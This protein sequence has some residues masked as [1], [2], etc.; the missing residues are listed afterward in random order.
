MR[1]C[2]CGL[3]T[4]GVGEEK[5]IYIYVIQRI[6]TENG[7]AVEQGS[8]KNTQNFLEAASQQ[9]VLLGKS[10]ALDPIV[11]IVNASHLISFTKHEARR[12]KMSK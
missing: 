9:K 1:I 11:V 5:N 6:K 2:A 7:T 12:K 10:D 3:I 8:T 4:N